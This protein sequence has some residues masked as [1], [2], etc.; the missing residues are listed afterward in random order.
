M[1][2]D[3]LIKAQENRSD[4]FYTRTAD[5]SAEFDIYRANDPDFLRGKTVYCP[6]DLPGE[7]AFPKYFENNFSVFGLARLVCSGY[8]PGGKGKL[9]V[10][11]GHEWVI[12]EMAGDG[13]YA[14]AES[15][16]LSNEADFI[17]TNP[18]FSLMHGFSRWLHE[19]GKDFSILAPVNCV[20]Y[21]EMFPSIRDG[22]CW[23]GATGFNKGMYFR[24]PEGY[25]YAESYKFPREIDGEAVMR[26]SGVCWLTTVDFPGRH[27]RIELHT[28]DWN[29]ENKAAKCK[30]Y[31]HYDHYDAI[32][33]PWAECIPS[34]Y[35]GIFGVPVTALNR[36]CPEQFEIVGCSYS[37]GRPAEW[38]PHTRMKADV[39][40]VEQ[41]KRLLCR[42]R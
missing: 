36:L 33:V 11:D 9:G 25:E 21:P 32:D 5:I 3:Q 15:V 20:T 13:N 38:D 1:G 27:A 10:Y 16:D 8:V 2:R 18:P 42:L 41:Y 19:S 39:D 26:V 6:C 12:T 40:G 23:A 37:H 31:R 34:D 24:V 30:G 35:A 14:N 29:R 17:A 4:E 22:E 7:S 28:M